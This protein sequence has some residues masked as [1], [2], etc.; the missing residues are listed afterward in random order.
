MYNSF[1]THNEKLY[2][3]MR[4]GGAHYWNYNDG[5]WHETKEAPDRWSFSF[6]SKKTRV[7]QAPSNTGASLNTK[8][9]WYIIADQ[10]ATK[11]DSNSYMTSMKGVKFKIGHKRPYWKSFSYNYPNQISYKE[12][13]IQILETILINLKSKNN[14]CVKDL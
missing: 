6:N 3:G 13:I 9:H 12:R 11:I 8:F 14:F 2:T 5:K 7:T 1:K 10:I 4:V